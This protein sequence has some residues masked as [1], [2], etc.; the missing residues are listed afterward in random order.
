MP[1]VTGFGTLG[2]I[3]AGRMRAGARLRLGKRTFLRPPFTSLTS[4][5]APSLSPPRS[6]ATPARR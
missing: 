5:G 3:A 2:D 1:P 6:E 4:A